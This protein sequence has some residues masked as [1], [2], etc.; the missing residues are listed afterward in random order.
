V[1]S[2]ILDIL[3]KILQV[4]LIILTGL[5]LLIISY[6]VFGRY[7]LNKS[8]SWTEEIARILLVWICFLGSGLLVRNNRNI[9][10][11]LVVQKFFS[12]RTAKKLELGTE[13]L[14]I[15]FS[16]LTLKLGTDLVLRN[17]RYTTEALHLPMIF[18]TLSVPLASFNVVLFAVGN[19]IR[20]LP[21]L[22]ESEAWSA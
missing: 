4:T 21:G 6:Q 10:L 13:I 2:K 11:D 18:F 17:L 5:I 16:L 15:L 14:I 1:Y 12:P 8:P 22:K 19:V 7:V 9:K 3:E 20:A